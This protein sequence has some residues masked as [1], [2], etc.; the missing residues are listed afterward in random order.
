MTDKDLVGLIDGEWCDSI[1]GLPMGLNLDERIAQAKIAIKVVREHERQN[2]RRE[3]ALR[4]LVGWGERSY[5]VGDAITKALLIVD[6]LIE[7][8]E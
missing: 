4:I 2:L 6:R 5:H 3:Y 1:A 8:T 7:V